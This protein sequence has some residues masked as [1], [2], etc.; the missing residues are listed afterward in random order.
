MTTSE[1]PVATAPGIL[2][3]P[4]GVWRQWGEGSGRGAILVHGAGAHS[5]WWSHLAPGLLAA[6]AA[7][8]IAPD[9]AGHGDAPR[10]H[11]YSLP[12]WAAS[13][14]QVA[15]AT[16]LTGR[17]VLVGHSLGGMVALL[18][19]LAE[20]ERWG[21]LVVVDSP[22]QR[23]VAP[24]RISGELD[25]KPGR[26]RRRDDIIARFR[27]IPEQP[28]PDARL[29]RR[30]ARDSVRRF[31]DGWG[32]KFDPRIF[33]R[34][35]SAAPVSWGAIADQLDGRVA[36]VAGGQSALV[37]DAELSAAAH[38][39]GDSRVH[40]VPTAHHHVVLDSP[41]EFIRLISAITS[42]WWD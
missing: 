6:G 26:Y 20:P 35:R 18:A 17:P 15:D 31:D 22:V 14:A 29:V 32:W 10:R 11:E 16:G 41:D 13:L 37:R 24:R 42:D 30:I 5:G 9:L 12:E 4:T 36:F 8:V 25:T 19:A 3:G 40:V 7:R 34:P 28:M 2:T 21:G 23:A 39:L 27:L 38:A 33:D 1:G